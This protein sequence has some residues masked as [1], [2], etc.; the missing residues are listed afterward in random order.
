MG[1]PPVIV[2]LGAS[3]AMERWNVTE[4]KLSHLWHPSRTFTSTLQ[5]RFLGFDNAGAF[6]MPPAIGG[7]WGKLVEW[8]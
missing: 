6:S 1:W 8:S 4:P 7:D 5:A 2:E 3:E